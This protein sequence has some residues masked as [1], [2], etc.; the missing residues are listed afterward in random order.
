MNSHLLL[1]AD[2]LQILLRKHFAVLFQVLGD[3][4]EADSLGAL[5]ARKTMMRNWNNF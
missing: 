2:A 5:L 4:K 1:E 3:Q